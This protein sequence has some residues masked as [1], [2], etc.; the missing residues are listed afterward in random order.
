MTLLRDLI[1][2]PER[3]HQSDF[4]LRLTEGVTDPERTLADYVV[5]EQLKRCFDDALGIIEKAV[6]LNGSFG[7]GKIHVMAVLNLLLAG[8]PEARSVV[9][10]APVVARHNGWTE[11]RRFLLVPYHMIGSVDLESAIL[12][13]YAEH[14][15]RLHPDAPVPGFYVAEHL[16]KDAEGMRARLGDDAF[17]AA[18][19]DSAAGDGSGWGG[20]AGG[21]EAVGSAAPG[22]SGSTSAGPCAA[23][24]RGGTRRSP[25]PA[26]LRPA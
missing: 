12:G 11:G 2:I 23:C 20:L 14:V 3:V 25:F 24:S 1:P 7:S 6:Y 10:L 21:W 5:T 18:L 4:V 8:H 9:E 26:M 16:F 22:R 17:F 13:G 19:N 15:R